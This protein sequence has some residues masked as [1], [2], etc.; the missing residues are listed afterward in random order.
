MRECKRAI[1]KSGTVT[2]E[3]AL[4]KTPTVVI[5]RTGKVNRW[6]AKHL[7]NLTHLPYFCIANI[8]AGEEVF[9]E[10]IKRSYSTEELREQ[11]HNMDEELIK[12][13]CSKL[14]QSL[15]SIPT[16]KRITELLLC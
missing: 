10:Y 11:L 9:P 3:L 16:S 15:E 2:L 12:E 1:A 4:H 8:L 13:K 14:L 5:Y 7:L 6:I